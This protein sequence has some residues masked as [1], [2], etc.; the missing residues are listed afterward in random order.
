M[1]DTQK[2]RDEF[3]ARLNKAL[4][5]VPS[6][7]P[8]RGRN[9]DLHE[10][11]RANGLSSSK[12][13]THKWLRAEAMPEKDNM[14]LIARVLGVRAEW[15]EYGHGDMHSSSGTENAEEKES[16]VIAD[17]VAIAT[18]RSRAVLDRIIRAASEGRLTDSDLELLDQIAARFEGTSQA[19]PSAEGSHKRLREKLQNNDPHSKS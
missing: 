10:L 6:V 11:L 17:L 14:R 2:I 8:A 16:N 12:Q 1:V 19:L 9:T 18:P 3:A 7:R 5:D 15:L 13:A 4:D